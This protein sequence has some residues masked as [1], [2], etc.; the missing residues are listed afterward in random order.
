MKSPDLR[1]RAS[2]C[3]IL[4]MAAAGLLFVV[5]AAPAPSSAPAPPLPPLNEKVLAFARAKL[6]TSVGDGNCTALA[7]AALKDAG[8]DYYPWSQRSG[9]LTWGQ[10]VASF[11]DALPGDILQFENV[12]LQGK[13]FVSR[14]RWVSWHYE[15]PHHTAIVAQVND[16]GNVVVLHQNVA[17]KGKD[18]KETMNVQETAL[19]TDSLQ[20]GGSIHI[21]RPVP[22]PTRGRRTRPGD[23]R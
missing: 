16:G 22:A 13:K 1:T 9:A 20:S 5:A 12:I 7:V 6:G 21:F 18:E 3:L 2:R 15:Y 4:P 8:A 11:K 10:P 14:R 19:P 23:E 17:L